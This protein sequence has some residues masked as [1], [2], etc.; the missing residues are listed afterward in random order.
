MAGYH[1]YSKSNNAD[2]FERVNNF[3]FEYDE[4]IRS[5]CESKYSAEIVSLA[6]EVADEVFDHNDYI[7]NVDELCKRVLNALNFNDFCEFFNLDAET[8]NT[9]RDI[10]EQV[11]K[12]IYQLKT[13][14]QDFKRS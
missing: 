11:K 6:I 14:Y 12:D 1:G 8:E 3:M 2:D 9:L 7:N 5:A 4:A 10:F 13:I